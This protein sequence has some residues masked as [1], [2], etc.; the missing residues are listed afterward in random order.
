MDL[1]EVLCEMISR[2]AYMDKNEWVA[3]YKRN[4]VP[5]IRLF[6]F[7]NGNETELIRNRKK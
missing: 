5:F 4:L 1:W 7:G 6:G 3:G 2:N